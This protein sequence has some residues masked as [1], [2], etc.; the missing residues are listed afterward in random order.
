M[1]QAQVGITN[2]NDSKLAEV[3]RQRLKQAQAQKDGTSANANSYPK[4]KLVLDGDFE[5]VGKHPNKAGYVIFGNNKKYAKP[6]L[7]ISVG[8]NGPFKT[9][10][11]PETG[12]PTT[13]RYPS[14]LD[15]SS[16]VLSEATDDTGIVSLVGSPNS[17]ATIKATSD[18]IKIHGREVV[19]I[20]AGGTQYIHGTGTKNQAKT[21]AVHIVAGNRSDGQFELQPMVKGKNLKEFLDQLSETVSNINSN[22]QKVVELIMKL[23]TVFTS[24]GSGLTAIPFTSVV[25]ASKLSAVGPDIP[26]SVTALCNTLSTGLNVEFK[27]VNFSEPYSPKN[28]LSRYNKVN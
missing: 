5:L 16:I 27:K 6:E 21:G 24:L 7:N 23:Q 28:I 18:M 3:S 15:A 17:R 10:V 13:Y 8:A 1:S 12:K 26:L 2:P 20:A 14:V 11:D 9:E 22:Q 25:G 19:E 4:P